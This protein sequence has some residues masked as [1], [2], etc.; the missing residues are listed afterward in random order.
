MDH[1][2]EFFLSE[3]EDSLVSTDGNFF[4]SHHTILEV[5]DRSDLGLH[6]VEGLNLFEIVLGLASVSAHQLQNVV[7]VIL[8]EILMQGELHVFD[9]VFSHVRVAHFF[10][11]ML[12]EI[13]I[14]MCE[15]F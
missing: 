5:R 14:R 9:P 8:L 7:K 10:H 1:G 13:S 12:E 3:H 6:L 11:V 15:V 4:L 2:D